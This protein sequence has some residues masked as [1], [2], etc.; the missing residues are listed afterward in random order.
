MGRVVEGQVDQS[1]VPDLTFTVSEEEVADGM[2]LLCMSRPVS[3]TVVIET[4]SDW[5]Y[6]LGVAEWQGA[7]GHITG[8]Q[9]EPLMGNKWEK[10]SIDD[11]S[12]DE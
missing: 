12:V 1:D 9:L 11:K 3:D 8:K 6:S 2:T 7:T 10:F 5:G 4:Q